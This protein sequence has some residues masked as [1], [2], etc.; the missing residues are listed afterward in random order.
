MFKTP[1]PTCLAHMAS[2]LER[3]PLASTDGG[4][5]LHHC[6]HENLGIFMVVRRGLVTDWTLWPARGMDEIRRR[7]DRASKVSVAGAAVVDAAE[8]ADAPRH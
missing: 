8:H 3:D 4:V 1:C 5:A 6:P 2:Q 7:V